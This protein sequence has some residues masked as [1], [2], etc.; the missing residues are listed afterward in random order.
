VR[1]DGADLEQWHREDLGRHI[2]YVPQS[3]ELFSGTV[4]E[5]IARMGRADAEAVMRAAKRAQVHDLILRLP[6]GYDTPVSEGGLTLSGGQR[7]RIALARALYGDPPIVV[8][9]E[10]NSNLDAEGEVLLQAVLNGLHE[11][12]V[13]IFVVAHRPSVLSHVDRILVLRDGLIEAFGPR[14]EV[15]AR[16]GSPGA[17]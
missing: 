13:T 11:E 9:D 10:P 4:G 7:Q 6:Q 8:L 14:Q 12:G 2:G 17:T 5:N 3:I 1:F 15:L 16:Y